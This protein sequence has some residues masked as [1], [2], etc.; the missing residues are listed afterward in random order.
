[1]IGALEGRAAVVTGAGRG[2]G[3]AIAQRLA[4]D[5]ARVA[6]SSTSAQSGEGSPHYCASKAAV[7]GLVRQLARE[8]APRGIRVN[9]VAPGPT[10]TPVMQGILAEW[11]KSMEASIPLGRMADPAEV[12]AA[13]AFLAGDQASFVT[14]SVLVANGGSYMF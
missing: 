7:I 6:I 14:G 4:A 11:I 12:A 2:I 10:D 8:L 5:G 3:R 9:A 1:M 13:V